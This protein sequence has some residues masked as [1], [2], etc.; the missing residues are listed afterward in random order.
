ME[1]KI[2]TNCH[3]QYNS[4]LSS[5]LLSSHLL[6]RMPRSSNEKSSSLWY[7]CQEGKRP[8][9]AEPSR[10]CAAQQ[11][12]YFCYT[13]G[14]ENNTKTSVSRMEGV[15]QCSSWQQAELPSLRSA[16]VFCQEGWDAFHKEYRD[17][18]QR[19]L[20]SKASAAIVTLPAPSPDE[21]ELPGPDELNS[22]PLTAWDGR[23]QK[24]HWQTLK[25]IGEEETYQRM[26]GKENRGSA[27][28]NWV[29][30]C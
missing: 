26:K 14:K 22:M 17:T 10:K 23:W 4:F 15:L 19:E 9:W 27:N 6:W 18:G 29:S 7:E 5:W 24:Y 8:E 25:T 28:D 12:G 21:S 16:S 11:K 13:Q 1:A 2:C 20:R 30:I 3:A